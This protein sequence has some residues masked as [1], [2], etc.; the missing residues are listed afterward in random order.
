ML[1]WVIRWCTDPLS[2]HRGGQHG[3]QRVKEWVLWP[4]HSCF[5]KTSLETGSKPWAYLGVYCEAMV[6]VGLWGIGVKDYPNI[7][8]GNGDQGSLKN[9]VDPIKLHKEKIIKT[10]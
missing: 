4:S 10:L 6:G 1:T 3:L 2:L 8:T 7:A 9:S 5:L